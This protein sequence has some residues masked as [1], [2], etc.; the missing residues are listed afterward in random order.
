MFRQRRRIPW[1]HPRRVIARLSNKL[2]NGNICPT[3]S[4][5][6]ETLLDPTSQNRFFLSG[7]FYIYSKLFIVEQMVSPPEM[8]LHSQRYQKSNPEAGYHLNDR[9]YTKEM[10][11]HEQTYR[12]T[13]EKAACRKNES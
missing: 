4:C 2:W 5:V 13:I 7:L 3:S 12:N 6:A 11:K 8:A 9:I 1:N 10:R